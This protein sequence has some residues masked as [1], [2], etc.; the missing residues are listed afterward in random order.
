MNTM[1]ILPQRIRNRIMGLLLC[2]LVAACLGAIP[3][4]MMPHTAQAAHLEDGA[5]DDS[6]HM[7][8]LIYDRIRNRWIASWMKMTQQYTSNMMHQMWIIGTFFDAKHQLETQRLFQLMANRAHKDYHPSDQMCRFGTTVRS[9]AAVDEL[10][11]V[12][13]QVLSTMMM[14]RETLAS[15]TTASGGNTT[16]KKARISQFKQ[17]YCNINDN[18]GRLAA[19]CRLSQNED[20]LD[21]QRGAPDERTN[22]DINYIQTVDNRYT[23]DINF[24]DGELTT[25]ETDILALSKNLFAHDVFERIPESQL[26]Q[27]FNKDDYLDVRSIIAVRGLARN[28]FGHIVGQRTRGTGVVSPFI[29]TLVQEM[30]VPENEINQFM[31]E[32]PSYFAQMETITRK[33]YQNPTFYANLY[34]KPTN[35]N[36]TGVAIQAIKLM[37]DRD[38]FESA[39]RREMLLSAI[40]ELRLRSAQDE[41]VNDLQNY[42][43]FEAIDAGAP[44]P[45]GP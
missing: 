3:L 19:M 9:L 34:D 11:R 23:L 40:L 18:N 21:F 38:R 29:R 15:H 1:K 13:G 35:V 26:N 43:E 32:H 36:R 7:N 4:F 17:F 28:S 33:M 22:K 27:E 39:L 25:D 20:G 45:A 16:D 12:N 8:Y 31:G 2:L 37:Q 30:G 42:E 41:L 24:T 14:N 10:S 5:L 44:A 6:N